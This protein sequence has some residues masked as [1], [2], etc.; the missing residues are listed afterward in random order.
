VVVVLDDVGR[1]LTTIQSTEVDQAILGNHKV[2]A[3]SIVGQA[4]G[5]TLSEAVKFVASR[6]ERLKTTC[7]GDFSAN[8]AATWDNFPGGY[9]RP[10]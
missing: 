8:N 9:L 10:S 7:P 3:L 4:S 1:R 5:C 2:A 6:Y